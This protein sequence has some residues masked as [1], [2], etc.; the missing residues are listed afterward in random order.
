MEHRRLI[1]AFNFITVLIFLLILSYSTAVEGSR[2]LTDRPFYTSLI[3][4][5]TINQAYSGPSHRGR[6]H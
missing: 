5:F 3:N 6:G 2:P 4:G 1:F